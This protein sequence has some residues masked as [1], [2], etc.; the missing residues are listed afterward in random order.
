VKGSLRRW[1]GRLRCHPV[2]VH[3]KANSDDPLTVLVADFNDDVADMPF[4]QPVAANLS[5]RHAS[6][7][8]GLSYVLMTMPLLSL[9]KVRPS[10]TSK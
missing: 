6:F 1:G 9:V 2:H 10:R 4:R 7:A 5:S 8:F 3:A